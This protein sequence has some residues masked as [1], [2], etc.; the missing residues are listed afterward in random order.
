MLTFK[1]KIDILERNLLSPEINYADSFKDDI[2]MFFSEFEEH[3]QNLSFLNLLN[4]EH[5]IVDWVNRLTSK[6]VMKFDEENDQ[7]SDFIFHAIINSSL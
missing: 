2:R 7:L 4:S 5:E 6:I 1:R 3:N